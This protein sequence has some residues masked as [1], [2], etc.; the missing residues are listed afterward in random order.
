MVALNHIRTGFR[1]AGYGNVKRAKV[2]AIAFSG[3]GQ[4]IAAAHNKRFCGAKNKW[5]LHAEES[6]I[7][8]LEKLKAFR[9]YKNITILVMRVCSYGI[10]MAK[11]CKNC[12]KIL[13]KYDVNVMYTTKGGRIEKL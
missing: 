8:K 2:S 13:D 5:T 12:Q 6:L 11:P 10:A 9:R 4:M 3:S 1:I 7:L